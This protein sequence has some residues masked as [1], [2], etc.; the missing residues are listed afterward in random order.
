LNIVFDLGGVVFTWQP[1][2]I[3][4]SVFKDEEEINKVRKEIFGHPDWSELDRGILSVDE[5]VERSA[6]RTKLSRQDISKLMHQVPYF[7]TP[8]SDTF[9][10]I[11]FVKKSNNKIFVLSN[12]HSAS[13][14]HLEKKYSILDIFNGKVISCK[15]NMVKPEPEIYKYLLDKYQLI[16]NETVFIDDTDKN[17]TAASMFGMKTIKFADPHQ[18]K[19]ELKQLGII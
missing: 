4:K 5:S 10:L 19:C 16:A 3:I 17:L 14:E 7:L 18:C 12:M 15:I 1:D 11:Y 2:K 13:I 6:L 8:I 9:K